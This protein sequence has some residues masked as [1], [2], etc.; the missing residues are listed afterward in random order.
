M[1]ENCPVCGEHALEVVR[2]RIYGGNHVLLR[3]KVKSA[4]CRARSCPIDPESVS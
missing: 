2:N 1:I 3:T 4:I